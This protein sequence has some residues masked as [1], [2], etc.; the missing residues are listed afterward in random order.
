[1][2]KIIFQIKNGKGV[3]ISKMID[4]EAEI[5]NKSS[6]IEQLIGSSARIKKME[7]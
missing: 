6:E 1:V 7:L 3:L 5:N 2:V 4:F